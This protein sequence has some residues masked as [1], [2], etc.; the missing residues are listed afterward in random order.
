MKS[1]KSHHNK[2][3]FGGCVELIP[4]RP[5]YVEFI[6]AHRIWGFP[7]HHLTHFV[8]QE[9]PRCTDRKTSPPDQLILVYPPGI[10]VLK[11][12]RLEQ[13][14]DPLMQG[15]VKRIHAE[16]HLGTLMIEETWVSE[17][18]VILRDGFIRDQ[19]RLENVIADQT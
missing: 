7:I 14:L 1:E 17:I 16:K 11:G 8:L 18:H 19:D 13:M 9:N 2:R 5:D 4:V 6:D 10:V 15:R 12:W 3:E